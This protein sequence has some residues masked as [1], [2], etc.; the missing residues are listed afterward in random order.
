VRRERL[1]PYQPQ[2]LIAACHAT[3]PTPADTDWAR[4]VA[5]YDRLAAIV[6]SW[7]VRLNR[8]VAVAMAS[9]PRAGLD[10]L[11]GLPGTGDPGHD[12]LLH[13]ARADL[14]RRLGQRAEAREEYRRALAGADNAG[15]RAY[16]ERRLAEVGG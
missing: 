13:A 16:L 15:E 3:A 14:L 8:A 7:T 4:I 9:G 6:P 12:R 11:D 1:G 5:L 2:A 10:L